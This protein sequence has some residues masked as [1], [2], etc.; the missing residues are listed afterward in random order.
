M[1]TH[2]V[3]RSRRESFERRSSVAVGKI[4]S[5]SSGVRI[6][7]ARAKHSSRPTARPRPVT[8]TRT[9]IA[10]VKNSP[11]R[12]RLGSFFFPPGSR[13]SIGAKARSPT[14]AAA[15]ATTAAATNTPPGQAAASNLGLDRVPVRH[16][17]GRVVARRGCRLPP[18]FHFPQASDWWTL[19]ARLGLGGGGGG[20]VRGVRD[21]G[22]CAGTAVCR[23][24]AVHLQRRRRAASHI[25]SV[26][27]RRPR[28]CKLARL[29]ACPGSAVRGATGRSTP[30]RR[31][32][33]GTS[34]RAACARVRG[35]T[36]HS[37]PSAQCVFFAGAVAPPSRRQNRSL[38]ATSRSVPPSE[39]ILSRYVD[40]RQWDSPLNS[41][42][43]SR[44]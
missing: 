28:L 15:A 18:P 36:R 30:P 33:A 4:F 31:P 27:R 24:P 35:R 22:G 39:Y 41:V 29:C 23:C 14:A 13:M 5:R 43:V 38:G 40:V 11:T 7:L 44:A 10:A 1:R 8:H 21:G 34:D 20:G 9:H 2:A 6:F 3:G 42:L 19:A 26:R 17:V 25:F 16:Y 32:R 12:P 37:C